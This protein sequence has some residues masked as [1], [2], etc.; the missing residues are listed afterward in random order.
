MAISWPAKIKDKG[1]I[2]WQF[3]HVIDIVPTLLEITGIPAPVQVDGIAQKP[4]EGVSLAHTFDA[5]AGGRDV[6]SRHRTQY[7][8][9]MGVQGLYNDGWMLSAVPL[10]APW[11]LAAAAVPS[12][13]TAFKFELYDT[14]NDWTQYT[15]VA[16]KNPEKMREMRDLMFGEFAK[17]Q[18]LPL[19][20]SAATRFPAPRPSMA[21]GRT[22][23][24]YS[25]ATVTNIPAG[26]MPSLANTS[27]T[28]TAEVDVPKAGAD[29]MIVNEG[30][31]FVGYGLYLL[32]GRPTFTYN[33]FG[34]KRT[35]WQGPELAPGKHRIEFNFRYDGLGVATLAY[36]NV[37]GVGRGG[38]G[39]LKVDGTVVATENLEY[40]EGMAMPLDTVF[41][42]GAAAGTPVDDKDYQIPF[43]FE[44]AITKLTYVL[45]RP[46]LTPEDVKKLVA[47][48][49][50]M[51]D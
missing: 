28:I 7:F 5:N 40:T 43:K 22:V 33:F 13:A 10:R 27:Y 14:K 17:Y 39:R 4:I 2:R 25:G 32:K 35:K 21:A 11:Q 26:N 15:D 31:M 19:D 3:H 24:N 16:A 38:T 1:G 12:P 34:L 18:V 50:Q 20:A 36:N 48:N 41:N 51:D 8:E 45:D 47:A 6:V 42:I 29:G 49:L 44:G 30:G 46:K 37:S 23:F 9:M